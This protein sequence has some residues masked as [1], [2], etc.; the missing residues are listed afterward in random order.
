MV[1]LWICGHGKMSV[2]RVVRASFNNSKF[3]IGRENWSVDRVDRNGWGLWICGHVKMSVDRVDSHS[4]N[5]S[6]FRV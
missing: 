2:D 5:N 6:K 1:G 4:F 3:R